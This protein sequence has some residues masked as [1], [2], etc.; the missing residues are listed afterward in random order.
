[1]FKKSIFI[2]LLLI[3]FPLIAFAN[4]AEPPSIII[5]TQNKDI[6]ISIRIDD[7]FIKLKEIKNIFG[8]YYT[9][10]SIDLKNKDY[11]LKIRTDNNEFLVNLD[12]K[13]KSY[14]NVFTLD[15]KNKKLNIGRTTLRSFLIVSHRVILTIFIEALVFLIFGYKNKKS[16]TIFLITNLLTQGA[17]NIF[18]SKLIDVTSYRLIFSLIFGE[19]FVFVIESILFSILID[20]HKKFRTI[21]YVIISN[22]LSLILGGYVISVLPI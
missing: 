20:E 2:L 18:L 15:I 5:I 9:L 14:N 13:L 4:S 6:D 22:I 10:Y 3:L 7:E 11:V 1:M 16:W 19:I 21:S 17:L 8:R 12:H